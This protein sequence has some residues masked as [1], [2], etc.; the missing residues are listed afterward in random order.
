MALAVI[1]DV[2]RV[3]SHVNAPN[4]EPSTRDRTTAPLPGG[5]VGLVSFPGHTSCEENYL[6]N[7]VK[8]LGSITRMW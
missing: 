8:F 4:F 7:Q 3:I 6:V 1:T 5:P 2:L